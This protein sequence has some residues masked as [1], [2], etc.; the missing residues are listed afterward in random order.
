MPGFFLGAMMEI[1]KKGRLPEEEI[2]EGDC[3]N[4][5]TEFRCKRC[6]GTYES[7]QRDGDFLR[8]TCPLC[9]REAIAYP[10]R[11]NK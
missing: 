5:K 9:N 1:I 8:V 11:N 6:E 3:H 4:C 7:Y 10:V 2:F